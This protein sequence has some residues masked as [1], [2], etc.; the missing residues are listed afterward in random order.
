MPAR[1]APHLPS[2]SHTFA[3][4]QTH[5][6]LQAVTLD[7]TQPHTWVHADTPL[8]S[9]NHMPA[10]MLLPIVQTSKGPMTPSADAQRDIKVYSKYILQSLSDHFLSYENGQ[11]VCCCWYVQTKMLLVSTISV[12]THPLIPDCYCWYDGIGVHVCLSELTMIFL[13]RSTASTGC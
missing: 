9:F 8:L 2:C 1:P 6:Y 5:T 10:A 13:H 11:H 12:L 3:F 4:M 7:F